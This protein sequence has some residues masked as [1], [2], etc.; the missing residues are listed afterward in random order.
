MPRPPSPAQVACSLPADTLVKL[1]PAHDSAAIY[2]AD[3]ARDPITHAMLHAFVTGSFPLQLASLGIDSTDR[4][5]LL[6][7][8]GPE[9][10]VAIVAAISHVAIVPLSCDAPPKEVAYTLRTCSA[11]CV[12]VFRPPDGISESLQTVMTDAAACNLLVVEAT[13]H[14]SADNAD[15]GSAAVGL[16]SLRH[17]CGPV[18]VAANVPVPPLCAADTAL[19]L[20]TSGTTGNPKAVPHT[21]GNVIVG[22]VC[23]ASG[24]QLCADDV[25]CNVMPLFHVGGV[26]RGVLAPIVAGGSIVALPWFDADS[27]W[28]A[29]REHG[30]THY[31]A[32]PTIQ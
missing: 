21:L 19:L 20:M 13:P 27:F 6:F 1:L 10:A 12:I 16:F 32:S 2:S 14:A 9:L 17:S 28:R 24:G 5:A 23:I 26:M 22:C 4:V 11:T 18:R 15:V 25:G 7:P 8:N 31:Y 29:I 3:A 30:A